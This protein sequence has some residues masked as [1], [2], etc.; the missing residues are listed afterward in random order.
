[1]DV[2]ITTKKRKAGK[3]G[4]RKIGRMARKP[5][6]QRYNAEMRWKRN[7]QRKIEKERKRQAKLNARKK[8]NDPPQEV[9]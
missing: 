5:A 7:K 4:T 8:S 9:G 1:M 6:H 2:I 3:G